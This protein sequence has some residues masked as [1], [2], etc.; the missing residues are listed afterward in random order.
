MI[1]YLLGGFTMF[2]LTEAQENEIVEQYGISKRSISLVERKLL[3]Y[4]DMILDEADYF[5]LV[6]SIAFQYE[7]IKDQVASKKYKEEKIQVYMNLD[8]IIAL[9]LNRKY[10]NETSYELKKIKY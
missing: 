9:E 6:I 2:K 7:T 4:C 10:S 1:S 8:E 3:T 5:E